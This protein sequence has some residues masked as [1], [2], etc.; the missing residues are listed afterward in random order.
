MFGKEIKSL[1]SDFQENYHIILGM[2]F[3][4]HPALSTIA[5]CPQQVD[6]RSCGLAQLTTHAYTVMDRHI[7]TLHVS[8]H[9]FH[10]GNEEQS[11]STTVY[12]FTEHLMYVHVVQ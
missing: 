3:Q 9:V 5:P 10:S 7:R 2:K 1:A 11:T 4:Y 12:I 6:C 8:M